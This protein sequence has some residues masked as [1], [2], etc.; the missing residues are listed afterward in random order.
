V[1]CAV[2]V[3]DCGAVVVVVVVELF[4]EELLEPEVA[5]V[6]GLLVVVVVFAEADFVELCVDP[7]RTTARATAP[8]TPD[9]PTA[10]VTAFMR[11]RSR[12]RLRCGWSGMGY[13]VR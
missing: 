6:V 7:G 8:A 5:L 3:V 10:E 2:D 4:E 12:R 1:A 9:T 13:S 11:A